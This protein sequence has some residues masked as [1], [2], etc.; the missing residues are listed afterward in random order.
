MAWTLED[1][2]VD[3]LFFCASLTGRGRGHTPFVHAGAG[4]SDTGAE[5]V[6]LDPRCPWH[7]HSRRLGAGGV[8]TESRGVV[9][10]L[11]IPKVIRPERRTYVVVS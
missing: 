1:D 11:R 4:T 9:Q 10:P 5:A 8:S 7:G 3:G 6:K 2:M